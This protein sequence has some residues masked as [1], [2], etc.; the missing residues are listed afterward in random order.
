MQKSQNNKIEKGTILVSRWG[1]DQTN[2]TFFLVTKRTQ[3][4]ATVV[5]IRTVAHFDNNYLGFAMPDMTIENPTEI[6]RKV[7]FWQGEENIFVNDRKIARIWDG[8]PV[9]VTSYA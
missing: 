1:Y 7:D 4:M 8:Q 2:A 3:K 5:Q 6:R 9:R